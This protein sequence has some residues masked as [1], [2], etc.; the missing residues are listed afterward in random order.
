VH[1]K[2]ILASDL[3]IIEKRF[4]AKPYPDLLEI[5]KSYSTV[6]GDS[7]YVIIENNT[8]Q[9]FKWGIT[10]NDA[11][12]QQSITIARAEGKRNINDDPAYNGSK[13]IFLQPE[14]KKL[15]FNQR[16]IVVA[17][18]YYVWSDKNQPYLVYLQNKQRP[19][20]FAGIYDVWQNSE[21]KELINGFAIITTTANEMLQRIGVRRMPVILPFQ[22]ETSWLKPLHLSE[23]LRFLVPFPSKKMN[24]YPV[25]DLVN[26]G[27]INDPSILKPIGEK[28]RKEEIHTT[29]IKSHYP[30]K[31]K[32]SSNEPY[33]KNK[34]QE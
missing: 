29:I 12:E 31:T 13:A 17:D 1:F 9:I 10:L 28:L 27:G 11:P 7:S 34:G 3:I 24:A 4:T 23:V 15:I 33:F 2:F 21:T 16:C 18:A 8:I 25:S 6:G 22:S 20:G 30:H 19:I 5:P 26:K 14:F 32:P